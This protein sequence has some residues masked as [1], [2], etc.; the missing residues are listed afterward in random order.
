MA[1]GEL[2]AHLTRESHGKR[3]EGKVKRSGVIGQREAED[4]MTE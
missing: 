2:V 4:Y 1:M 3:E